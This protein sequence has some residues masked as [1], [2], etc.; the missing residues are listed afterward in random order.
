MF[1]LADRGNIIT[2]TS[3]WVM[4]W[5]YWSYVVAI[6]KKLQNKIEIVKL[7]KKIVKL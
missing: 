6:G 3:M 5:Y 1:G 2:V 7:K 4:F